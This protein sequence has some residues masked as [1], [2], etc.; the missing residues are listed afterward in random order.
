MDKDYGMRI[1][2]AGINVRNLDESIAWY[3]DIFG[4]RLVKRFDVSNLGGIMPDCAQMCQGS[5]YLELYECAGGE[6][7]SLVDLE[8]TLGVKHFSFSMERLGEFLE[9]LRQRGDVEIMVDNYYSEEMCGI[10]GGDR[11]AYIKDCNGIL[12]ELQ[13]KHDWG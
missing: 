13:Q 12:I 8:Y 5:F 11:T 6:P 2:H 7:Y 4:F 9:D 3:S 1:H 10:P